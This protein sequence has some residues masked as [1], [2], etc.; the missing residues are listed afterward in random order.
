MVENIGQPT[1]NQKCCSRKR[2]TREKTHKTRTKSWVALYL[3]RP[4]CGHNVTE[5]ISFIII[6]III[7]M[8]IICFCVFFRSIVVYVTLPA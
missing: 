6:I 3:T 4:F 5:E 2:N 1:N 7:I 8:F